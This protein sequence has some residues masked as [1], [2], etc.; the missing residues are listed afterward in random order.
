MKFIEVCGG[1]GGLS[2]GF[3]NAGFEPE[4]IN[5]IDSRCCETLRVNHPNVRIVQEDMTKLDLEEYKGI[6]VLMGGVPCQ[7]FSQA[8]KRK[9]LA[10]PRGNLILEFANIVETLTPKVFLIENVMGLATHNKGET[11]KNVLKELNRTNNYNLYHKVLNANDYGVAQKR[12]RLF[13]IGVSK[14]IKKKFKFPK[15]QE[16]KPVLRDVLQNVPPS[17]GYEYPVRK[18]QIMDMVPPGGCWINLPEEVQIEYMK[19]SRESG[20]GKR[21]IARRLSMDE[22]CLTLTTSPCQKQTERCHPTETRPFNIREYARI[23]SFPD[24]FVFCGSKAQIYKQIGNAVPILLATEVA[25]RVA[26]LF[27][28]R[29]VRT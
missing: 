3:I 14:D 22:A 24:E 9:G 10:D 25:K 23:Q 28:K 20:G 6:D 26:K 13:I 5:E 19:K 17:E 12:K 29:S 27:I 11:L 2:Q 7:S 21:G 8:G 1:I 4:F 15:P 16:Y 18:R